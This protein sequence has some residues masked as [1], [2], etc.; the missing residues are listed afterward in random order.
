MDR[1]CEDHEPL[2]ITRKAKQSLVLVSLKDF[3][4][5]EETAFL[6]RTPTNARR[7]LAATQALEAW[8]SATPR[9]PAR[10]AYCPPPWAPD[11]RGARKVRTSPHDMPCVHPGLQLQHA[12]WS[13]AVASAP[14]PGRQPPDCRF[15]AWR[16]EF[17]VGADRLVKL[18]GEHTADGVQCIVP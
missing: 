14:N 4:E 8:G 13:R 15:I 16:G 3:K 7:L 1:V 18:L 12:L 9:R 10:R 11:L 5:W 17:R 2:V 6:L